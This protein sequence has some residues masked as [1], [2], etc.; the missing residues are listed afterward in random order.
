LIFHGSSYVCS[1][2]DHVV[3]K[4]LHNGIKEEVKKKGNESPRLVITDIAV[5]WRLARLILFD[6]VF[7]FDLITER[8]FRLAFYFGFVVVDLHFFLIFFFSHDLFLSFKA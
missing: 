4:I 6:L 5:T 2:S 8:I 3:V 7:F 1:F